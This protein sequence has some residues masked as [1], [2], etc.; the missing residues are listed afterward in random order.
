M[1]IEAPTSF[2]SGPSQ[3]VTSTLRSLIYK[4]T[5]LRFAASE[6]WLLITTAALARLAPS[7]SVS[8]MELL[9]PS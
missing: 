5:V 6:S 9:T 4:V 3:I 7:L 1:A 2:P 8:G